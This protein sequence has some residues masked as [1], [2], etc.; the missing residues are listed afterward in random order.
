MSSLQWPQAVLAQSS[1]NQHGQDWHR[2][3]PQRHV[4]FSRT[5]KKT[6]KPR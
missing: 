4:Q 3:R 6:L 5:K 1:A 2:H